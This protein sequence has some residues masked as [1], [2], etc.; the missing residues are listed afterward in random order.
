MKKSPIKVYPANQRQ[1]NILEWMIGN[2]CNYDCSFCSP[3]IKSGSKRFL[4]L[5]TYK[6]I[7][8]KAI[9]ESG[10]KK[11]WFKITGGEPTLY[12]NII[13]LMSYIKERG[14]FTYLITNGSRT[15]R[16]WKELKDADCMDVIAFSYHAE[17]TDNLQRFIDIVNLFEDVH[18]STVVNVTCVPKFFDE[19]V[20]AYNTVKEKCASLLNLQQINDEYGMAKYTEEQRQILL[21][22]NQSRTDNFQRK[23]PSN[24]KKEYGYHDGIIK[25]LYDDGTEEMHHAIRFIKNGQDNFF[26]YNC[27]VGISNIRIEHET[28]QRSVCGAGERWSIYDEKIFKNNSIICPFQSCTCTLDIIIPKNKETNA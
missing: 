1:T 17:Q 2:T 26:G 14:Q 22:C 12:P 16:F 23:T 3:E 24:T 18:T 28:I 13:E 5:S 9:L 8:D 20:L 15:M 4:D 27:D 19:S 21:K 25:Y 10:D 11:I 6:N 7:I